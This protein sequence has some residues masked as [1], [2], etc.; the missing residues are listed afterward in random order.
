M[1][2]GAFLWLATYQ[3]GIHATIAGVVLGVLTPA[4]PLLDEDRAVHAATEAAAARLDVK[5]LRR[6][7][8]LLRESV[9]VAERV[10]YALHP[11]SS[12]IVLPIFALANAGIDL[13][14]DAPADAVGSP[15]TVGIVVG[16]VAGKTTGVLAAS[17][18]GF[19]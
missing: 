8:F 4:K 10:Q 15:V 18:F 19:R 9:P 3:S 1:L 5:R 6:L 11:W 14:G 13:R 17:W 12:Y 7:R 16:L 2:T